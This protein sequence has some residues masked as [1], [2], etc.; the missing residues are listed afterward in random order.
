[1]SDVT[2]RLVA[3]RHRDWH[4]PGWWARYG[5]WIAVGQLVVLGAVGG[6]LLV[7]TGVAYQILLLVPGL[8]VWGFIRWLIAASDSN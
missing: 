8:V 4:G 6:Y 5:P 1:M 3:N 2:D 7:S